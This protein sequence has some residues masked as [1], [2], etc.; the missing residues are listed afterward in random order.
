MQTINITELIKKIYGDETEITIEAR[1]QPE[2]A[3][4]WN[5][6]FTIW[7]TLSAEESV[8][9]LDWAYSYIADMIPSPLRDY[10]VLDLKYPKIPH[11]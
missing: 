7:T 11:S 1:S 8:I 4:D 10:I 3:D 2:C 6:V 9:R 5:L